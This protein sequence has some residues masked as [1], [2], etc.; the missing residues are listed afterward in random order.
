LQPLATIA[1]MSLTHTRL[2][3]LAIG[4]IC[5]SAGV[6]AGAIA[7]AG[8]APTASATHPHARRGLLARAVH[9]DVVLATAHGFATATFDRGFVQSVSGRQLT[10]REGTRRRTYRTVTLTIPAGA[11]VRDNGKPATL[12]QLS[13]GQR[14][15]VLRGPRQT[16]VIARTPRAG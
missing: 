3:Q 4:A 8:A 12:G 11:R 15:R 2:K 7:T 5:A 6:G 16:A 10:L 9:G 13:P 14:V 1:G